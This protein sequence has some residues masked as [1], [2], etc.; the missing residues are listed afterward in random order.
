[1]IELLIAIVF[2]WVVF[3]IIQD[4]KS[5]EIANW[6]NFSLVIFV[7]VIRFFYSL[8]SN[9]YWWFIFGL[10]G[11]GVFF[12]LGHLFYHARLF[13][14]GDA[15]LF[16]AFGVV[17]PLSIIWLENV[18]FAMIFVMALLFLGGVYS[19]FYSGVLALKN[20]KKFVV[21]CGKQFTKNKGILF[22]GLGIAFIAAFFIIL[23]GEGNS[24]F[25][26]GFSFLILLMPLLY[27]Y[28][29]AIEQS[30]MLK[31]V[32]VDKVTIGDWL[33]EDI[34]VKGRKILSSWE[35]ISESDLDFLKKNFDKKVLIK[36]GI[37]FSPSF[38]LA[39][40]AIIIVNYVGIYKI[41][42]LFY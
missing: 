17:V 24:L 5:R 30:C 35:G 34:E 36:Y 7:L 10:V 2:V 6:L 20:K 22:V 23:F 28:T 15:K 8:F 9:N 33:V 38:L 12:L 21:E 18:V 40:I 25:L 3:A 37:P 16:I 31:E 11:L 4:L 19:L 1:M 29:K 39:F 13:A 27:I 26:L 41:L 42:N 32:S 14:G